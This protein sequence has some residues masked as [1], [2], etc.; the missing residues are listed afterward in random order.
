[1]LELIF[2][3]DGSSL[4]NEA[5]RSLLHLPVPSKMIS[6]RDISGLFYRL[7]EDEA[8]ERVV[9][10][11][12][13][14]FLRRGGTLANIKSFDQVMKNQMGRFRLPSMGINEVTATY[15]LALLQNLKRWDGKAIPFSALVGD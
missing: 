14:E 4:H 10:P 1:E 9:V 3:S 8:S 15:V 12:L 5:G 2:R 7:A 6:Q 13:V 11:G